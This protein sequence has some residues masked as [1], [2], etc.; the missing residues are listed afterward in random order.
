MYC[1]LKCGENPQKIAYRYHNGL[2]QGWLCE[3]CCLC[4]ICNKPTTQPALSASHIHYYTCEQHLNAPPKFLCDLKKEFKS[5]CMKMENGTIPF[6]NQL[7]Q[8]KQN[9]IIQANSLLK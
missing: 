9:E 7:I 6:D 1:C 5:L 3:K 4:E 8:M 2:V